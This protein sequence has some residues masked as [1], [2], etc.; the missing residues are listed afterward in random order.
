MLTSLPPIHPIWVYLSGNPLFALVI[1]LGA[2][3]GRWI[4]NL[5]RITAWWQRGFALGVAAHGLGTS[6]ALSVHPAAGALASLGMG[7][8]GI[9]G[10][11]LIPLVFRYF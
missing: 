3:L 2:V 10:S 8:S 6:R 1:T 11:V 5:L 7:L 4:F 9:L